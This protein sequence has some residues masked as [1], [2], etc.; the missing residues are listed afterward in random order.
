M[1]RAKLWLLC[2]D[3]RKV[4]GELDF[5]Q[6]G[7]VAEVLDVLFPIGAKKHRDWQA[8]AAQKG[9]IKLRHN[10]GTECHSVITMA[11]LSVGRP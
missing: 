5:K 8:D 2:R 7:G 4:I 3:W 9:L 11:R 10:Y 6:V 1:S